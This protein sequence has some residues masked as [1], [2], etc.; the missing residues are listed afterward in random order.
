MPD[1]LSKTRRLIASVLTPAL[2]IAGS[3]LITY[4]VYLI[5]EPAAF[6]A[7]GVLLLVGAWDSGQ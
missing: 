6:L 1:L 3:G 2:A 7:G 5:Y 4:G